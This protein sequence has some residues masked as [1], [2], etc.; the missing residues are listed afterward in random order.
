MGGFIS[1]NVK[2]L[3][4]NNGFV[5]G[6][7]DVE[8]IRAYLIKSNGT[9]LHRRIFRQSKSKRG[10]YGNPRGKDADDMFPQIAARINS[11]QF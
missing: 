6:L 4:V 1:L 3:P 5:G 2:R 10:E 7:N 8:G 11:V 9:R